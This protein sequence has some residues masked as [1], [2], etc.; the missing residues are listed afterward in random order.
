MLGRASKT[1]FVLFDDDDV[2]QIISPFEDKKILIPAV[3]AVCHVE[4]MAY[5][6]PKDNQNKPH[7][8]HKHLEGKN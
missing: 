4:G 6:N 2:H 8:C 5:V 1:N 7:Y 3:C